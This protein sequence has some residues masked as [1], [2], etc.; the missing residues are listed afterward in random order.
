L[1]P[2]FEK[3]MNL[4]IDKETN[5]KADTE[6]IIWIPYLIFSALNF[7]KISEQSLYFIILLVLYLS[8]LKL[9]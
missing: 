5:L 6:V 3:I 8:K 9:S 1:L 7:I 2:I 4:G